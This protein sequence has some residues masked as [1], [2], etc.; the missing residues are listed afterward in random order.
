LVGAAA[1]FLA[2]GVARFAFTPVLPIMQAE[3]RFSDTISGLL[4]SA[5]Y[6]GYLLG[7]VYTR[8]L[9]HDRKYTTYI[10]SLILSVIL[11]LLMASPVQSLWYLSGFVR[12]FS[13][14]V[15][16]LSSEDKLELKKSY[17]CL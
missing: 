9:P 5:N 2:M 7:A 10:A 16:V 4:A 3:F 12:F 14:I 15:F 13:A 6:L 8:F 11:I 17:Q 1:L